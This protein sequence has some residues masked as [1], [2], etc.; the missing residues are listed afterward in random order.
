MSQSLAEY[1]FMTKTAFTD[2]GNAPLF[3]HNWNYSTSV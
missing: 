2:Y 3:I 1:K